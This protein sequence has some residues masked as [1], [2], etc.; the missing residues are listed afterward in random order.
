MYDFVICSC[1]YVLAL[2]FVPMTGT[3]TVSS[4]YK[5]MAAVCMAGQILETEWLDFF[6]YLCQKLPISYHSTNVI[7]LWL[8][9]GL[10]LF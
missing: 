2:V 10:D 9:S 5:L 1:V 6:S 7:V 3:G 4:W 8:Y